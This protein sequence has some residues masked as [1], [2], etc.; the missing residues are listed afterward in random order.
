[1]VDNFKWIPP[2][3]LTRR[4]KKRSSKKPSGRTANTP[5]ATLSCN[6]LSSSPPSWTHPSSDAPSL[7]MFTSSPP[8]MSSPETAERPAMAHHRKIHLAS[9]P[10]VDRSFVDPSFIYVA[11]SPEGEIETNDESPFI[12]YGIGIYS[13][14]KQVSSIPTLLPYKQSRLGSRI[15][16]RTPAITGG[17]APSPLPALKAGLCRISRRSV[18]LVIKN[19]RATISTVS[20]PPSPLPSVKSCASLM[21]ATSSSG[22]SDSDFDSISGRLLTVEEELPSPDDGVTVS[23]DALSAFAAALAR[24]RANKNFGCISSNFAGSSPFPL[25]PNNHNFFDSFILSEKGEFPVYN[26]PDSSSLNQKRSNLPVQ[27][28]HTTTPPSSA[29]SFDDVMGGFTTGMTP[30]LPSRSS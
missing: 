29:F 30:Y 24:S 16:K 21:Q 6:I 3:Q 27:I 5:N 10:L 15:S 4:S 23:G 26:S 18:E 19:G 17:N 20:C 13:Q 28:G 11:S 25:I 9:S 22:D 14:D 2:T 1:M 12:N 7:A 8:R